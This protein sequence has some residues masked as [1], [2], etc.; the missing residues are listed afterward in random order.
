MAPNENLNR[1]AACFHLSASASARLRGRPIGSCAQAELRHHPPSPSIIAV[2]LPVGNAPPSRLLYLNHHPLTRLETLLLRNS[3]SPATARF[4]LT[5]PAWLRKNELGVQT[6]TPLVLT[7]LPTPACATDLPTAPDA[8]RRTPSP[9]VATTHHRVNPRSRSSPL[10]P[11]S[12]FPQTQN[13]EPGTL[14]PQ[15]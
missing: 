15:S 5:R 9:S 12:K 2:R 4:P 3:G 14:S 11:R 6:E 8:P 1:T 10:A 7:C 13:S